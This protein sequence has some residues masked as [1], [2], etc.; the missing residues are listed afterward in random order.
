MMAKMHVGELFTWVSPAKP[1]R[2]PLGAMLLPHFGAVVLP[3]KAPMGCQGRRLGDRYHR[4]GARTSCGQ[5]EPAFCNLDGEGAVDRDTTSNNLAGID[6]IQMESTVPILKV[7][8][9]ERG[10]RK[11]CR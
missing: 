3:A 5:V 10:R 1:L 9:Q 4:R 7:A 11:I 2:E 6:F 8:Q